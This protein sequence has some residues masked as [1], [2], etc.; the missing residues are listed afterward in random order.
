[1]PHN[2]IVHCTRLSTC[3]MQYILYILQKTV[4][5]NPTVFISRGSLWSLQH[6]SIQD[7]LLSLTDGRQGCKTA[8][9]ICDQVSMSH[10]NALGKWFTPNCSAQ[11]HKPENNNW[12]NSMGS[13]SF[14]SRNDTRGKRGWLPS[15]MI[16][17]AVIN[18]H[19]PYSCT[20]NLMDKNKR[21]F[22]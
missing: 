2:I 8:I 3:Y 4:H 17:V 12:K 13:H 7:N 22:Y 6:T 18:L 16:K 14:P 21:A 20:S 11:R 1:M 19:T 5:N 15:A 9:N 10:C